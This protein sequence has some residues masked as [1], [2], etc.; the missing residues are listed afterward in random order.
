[1][2]RAQENLLFKQ[3]IKDKKLKGMHRE[4]REAKDEIKNYDYLLLFNKI[5]LR[6]KEVYI[7][8]FKNF[9]TKTINNRSK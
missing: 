1:M 8:I 2:G 7:K 6:I 9:L 4:F 5:Y 3:M